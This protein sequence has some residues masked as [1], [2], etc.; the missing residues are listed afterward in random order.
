MSVLLFDIGATKVRLALAGV[1][2]PKRIRVFP[3]PQRWTEAQVVFHQ[4]IKKISGGKKITAVIGGTCGTLDLSSLRLKHVP[5]IPDW[6]G[7]PLGAMLAKVT[8]T[9]KIRIENDANLAGL[10]EAVFGAGKGYHIVAYLGIGT[11][12][13]GTRIVDRQLDQAKRGFRPGHQI[14]DLNGPL[15]PRCQSPGHWE[16]YVSGSG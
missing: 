1:T 9:K 5:N 12:A 3:T 8:T 14:I 13:G 15:C 7:K 16:T 4:E 6:S 11:G 10:G 2:M